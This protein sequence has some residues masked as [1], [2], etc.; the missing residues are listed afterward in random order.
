MT[1]PKTLWAPFDR[2][3]HRGYWIYFNPCN[4]NAACDWLWCHDSYDGAPDANDNR[5]GFGS[6]IEDCK[7]QIDA[8]IEEHSDGT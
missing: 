7:A 5:H 6:S 1:Y 2:V 8:Y 4:V 3:A